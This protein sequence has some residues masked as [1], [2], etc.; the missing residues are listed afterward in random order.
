[1][2]IENLLLLVTHYFDTNTIPYAVVGGF[3][4]IVW[5]RGR[6]TYDID[7]II[8]HN[9]L[10]FKD[11]VEFMLRNGLKTSETDLK[12]AFEEHSHATILSTDSTIFR[13]D[14]KGIYSSLDRETIET[15]KEI[16]Y[17]NQ[18]IKFGS[19][20]NL[21]AHK[22]YFGSDRDLEDALVVLIAQEK[23]LDMDYL[24]LLS[25]KLRVN[26]KLERLL[27]IVKN[28]NI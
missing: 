14:L 22:L 24:V 3:S 2:K 15:A 19:P 16:N 21:I 4:A 13:I 8:E 7:I 23:A 11:F 28:K 10:N 26:K 17:K 27:E 9:K 12:K 20:E 6:S 25:N 18:K 5:G 1:M